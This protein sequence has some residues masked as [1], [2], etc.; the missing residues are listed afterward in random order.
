MLRYLNNRQTSGILSRCHPYKPEVLRTSDDAG[1]CELSSSF[2][3]LSVAFKS[4]SCS[5]YITLKRTQSSH[6]AICWAAQ[7]SPGQQSNKMGGVFLRT[8][9]RTKTGNWVVGSRQ[10]SWSV[11]S[12]GSALAPCRLP[13]SVCV[14]R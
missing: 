8:N 13:G 10:R 7:H 11:R 2:G 6:N 4:A 5:N 12:V 3:G 1:E 9:E 14:Q